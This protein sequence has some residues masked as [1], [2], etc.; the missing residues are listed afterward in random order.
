MGAGLL[1]WG[2]SRPGTDL[3]PIAAAALPLVLWA[4]IMYLSARGDDNPEER[5]QDF[6]EVWT[7]SRR[8][9]VINILFGVLMC[10]SMYIGAAI[11][12]PPPNTGPYIV[13]MFGSMVILFILNSL[14]LK[15]ALKEGIPDESDLWSAG[16]KR[17]ENISTVIS[18]LLY[19]AGYPVLRVLLPGYIE[20]LYF[21]LLFSLAGLGLGYAAH[22]YFTGRFSGFFDKTERKTQIVVNIY[23]ISLILTL[24]AAAFANY[25]TARENTE[26]RRYRIEKKSETYRNSYVWLDIDGASKRFE[27]R[28]DAFKQAQAGDTMNVVVGK[29]CLGFEVIL[30]FGVAD[31]LPAR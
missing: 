25:R 28:L 5:L 18:I 17:L 16:E 22:W 12:P 24:C 8:F 29:G 19:V 9:R 30:Q 31:T 21:A 27:P 20:E 23:L 6:T 11:A 13:G 2:L 3:P 1:A 7:S 4:G 10:L 15:S 14:Y 26:S